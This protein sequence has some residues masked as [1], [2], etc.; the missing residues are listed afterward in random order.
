MSR[1]RTKL[2]ALAVQ[3][4]GRNLKDLQF[5][6]SC[7]T[8]TATSTIMSAQK[9]PKGVSAVRW[10]IELAR[11]ADSEYYFYYGMPL[12]TPGRMRPSDPFKAPCKHLAG[13]LLFTLQSRR[14]R[15]ADPL[16]AVCGCAA[17]CRQTAGKLIFSTICIFWRFPPCL[18]GWILKS[19]C[20]RIARPR[21]VQT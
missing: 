18:T 17:P 21:K 5:T 12:E 4:L 15:P 1:G 20:A 9:K 19:P 14:R 16:Q 8:L 11:R 3:I 6:A 13:G 7:A 2:Q 10:R